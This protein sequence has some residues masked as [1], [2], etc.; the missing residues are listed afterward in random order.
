M[1]RH[2]TR[3]SFKPG[4]SGGGRRPKGVPNKATQE[5]K[6]LALAFTTKHYWPTLEAR[7][8]SGNVLWPEMQTVLAYA[9]GKP[10]E[11]YEHSG[12]DGKP[13]EVLTHIVRVIIDGQTA[14]D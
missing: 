4:Q 8:K 11:T 10:K 5:A 9:H 1:P 13:I 14:K 2:A 12:P 6:E 3:T 7:W